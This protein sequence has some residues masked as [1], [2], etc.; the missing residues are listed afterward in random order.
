MRYI[1]LDDHTHKVYR[2]WWIYII[3]RVFI[4]KSSYQIHINRGENDHNLR[5]L[6]KP[7]K[8]SFLSPFY[9]LVKSFEEEIKLS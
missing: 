7:C 4:K 1:D 6:C 5:C 8:N 9:L 2:C 3:T